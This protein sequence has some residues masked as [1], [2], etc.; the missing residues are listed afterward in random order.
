MDFHKK[1]D[2]LI[3]LW[4]TGPIEDEWAFSKF[5]DCCREEL[6]A[7]EA[8]EK[9]S[10]VIEVLLEERDEST[11]IELVEVILSLARHSNT[12]EVPKA[13][14]KKHKGLSA[15][16]HAFDQYANGKLNELLQWYRL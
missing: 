4:K 9:I 10:H 7:A 11:A 2:E 15:N 5:R 16:F 6:S 12:T 13:L 8:F 14:L 1:L 3:Q